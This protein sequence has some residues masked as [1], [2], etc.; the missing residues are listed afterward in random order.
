M[1][2]RLVAAVEALVEFTF[3]NQLNQ[4]TYPHTI[5]AGVS[6]VYDFRFKLPDNEAWEIQWMGGMFQFSDVLLTLA[7]GYYRTAA[8]DATTP[9]IN[10][11]PI[12]MAIQNLQDTIGVLPSPNGAMHTLANVFPSLVGPGQWIGGVF[13]FANA[14]VGDQTVTGGHMTIAFRRWRVVS[15]PAV[16]PAT[17]RT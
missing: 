8:P 15:E 2:T 9:V 10:Q 17:N 4:G 14:D 12:D 11:L 6:E 5:S 1:P 3:L 16:I 7:N 13:E